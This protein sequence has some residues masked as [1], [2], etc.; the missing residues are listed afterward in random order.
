MDLSVFILIVT[1]VNFHDE[2]RALNSCEIMG[3]I[4]FMKLM[5]YVLK[6]HSCCCWWVV[7]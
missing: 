4:N 2:F 6:T 3:T 1:F 5:C 7:L